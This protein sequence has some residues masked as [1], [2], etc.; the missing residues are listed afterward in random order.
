MLD[1]TDSLDAITGEAMIDNII[2]ADTM[3]ARLLKMLSE[4]WVS[5]FEALHGAQSMCLAQR[6]SEWIRQGMPIQKRWRKLQS[7]KQVREYHLTDE[8]GCYF[9]EAGERDRAK[10]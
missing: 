4:G 5:P 10:I 2:N 8:E 7:G 6:C 1:A 9:L 3:Q